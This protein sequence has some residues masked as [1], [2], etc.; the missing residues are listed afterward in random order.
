MLYLAYD[1]NRDSNSG[2][3]ETAHAHTNDQSSGEAPDTN[4]EAVLESFVESLE[5]LNVSLA[6]AYIESVERRRSANA[7]KHA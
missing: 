1:A 3:Q 4:I 2:K 7:G 5:D 6:K